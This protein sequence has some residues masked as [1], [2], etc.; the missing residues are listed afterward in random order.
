MDSGSKVN[1]FKNHD[2]KKKKQKD[3]KGRRKKRKDREVERMW[4]NC[5]SS[6]LYLHLPVLNTH[7]AFDQQ[8][9]S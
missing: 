7:Q 1:S 4:V 9:Y 2:Q 3:G 8:F 6:L 5:G